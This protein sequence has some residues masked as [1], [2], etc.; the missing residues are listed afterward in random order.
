MYKIHRWVL[1]PYILR[2]NKKKTSNC[3]FVYNYW[4]RD[5]NFIHFTQHFT[6]L[7]I[8]IYFQRSLL[9]VYVYKSVMT[10]AVKWII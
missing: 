6:K 10:G 8:N 1:M 5:R 4:I 3:I 2:S 9:V 7:I